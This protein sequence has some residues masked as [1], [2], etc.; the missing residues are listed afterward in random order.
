MFMVILHKVKANFLEA[1]RELLDI[2]G[3]LVELCAIAVRVHKEPFEDLGRFQALMDIG[4]TNRRDLE[5]LE[6]LEE[7]VALEGA[8][9]NLLGLRVEVSFS[10]VYES[11]EVEAFD[12]DLLKD[13]RVILGDL[14]VPG[15]E[16]ELGL[17]R[18]WS[19]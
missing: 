10:I 16:L 1:C 9:D 6:S 3:D 4:L 17:L 19:C 14:D 11:A 2:K 8:I 12:A 5:I 18:R 7:L 15:E 13:W